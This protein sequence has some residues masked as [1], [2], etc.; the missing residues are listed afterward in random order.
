MNNNSNKIPNNNSNSQNQPKLY[1]YMKGSW[2]EYNNEKIP[3]L[4]FKNTEGKEY[5]LYI[6]KD[7]NK[8]ILKLAPGTIIGI[9]KFKKDKDNKIFLED[10]KIVKAV[11]KKNIQGSN[12]I[13]DKN[14]KAV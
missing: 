14:K 9:S 7:S 13:I 2:A 12:E 3:M 11:Q 6:L 4:I 10:Y 5:P 1:Q 8:E